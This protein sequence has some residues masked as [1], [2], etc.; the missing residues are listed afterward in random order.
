MKKFAIIIVVLAMVVSGCGG[1]NQFLCNPTT[2]QTEAA[3]TLKAMAEAVLAGVSSLTGNPV[4]TL[5][6]ANVLP[7]ANKVISG[8]CVL[9]ADWDT[10]VSSLQQAA[11]Q[12]SAKTFRG[13]PVSQVIQDLQNIKW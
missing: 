1:F 4:V 2:A 3:N 6:S 12:S 9:Q 10:A 8:Y 7:V 5:I 11:T 13:A